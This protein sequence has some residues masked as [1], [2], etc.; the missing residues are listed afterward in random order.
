[1]SEADAAVARVFLDAVVVDDVRA[2][3]DDLAA[4]GLV[5]PS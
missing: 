4:L 2:A 3:V 1:M 5:E